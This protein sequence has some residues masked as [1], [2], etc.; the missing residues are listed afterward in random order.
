VKKGKKHKRLSADSVLK[1]Q[2]EVVLLSL[3][4]FQ[5]RG[6]LFIYWAYSDIY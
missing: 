4:R 2:I 1:N 6:Y 5:P 3:N